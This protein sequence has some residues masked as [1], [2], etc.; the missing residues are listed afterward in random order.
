MYNYRYVILKYIYYIV[1]LTVELLIK[2]EI[3]M[4]IVLTT[5]CFTYFQMFQM[6]YSDVHLQNFQIFLIFVN[7]KNNLKI[8]K[9]FSKSK[10][11]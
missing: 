6:C 11:N 5:T 3:V 4:S 9:L 7:L 2:Q 10:W 1:L 8:N